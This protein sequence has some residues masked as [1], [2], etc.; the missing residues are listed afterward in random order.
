MTT[1]DVTTNPSPFLAPSSRQVPATQAL[2]MYEKYEVRADEKIKKLEN[3]PETITPGTGTLRLLRGNTKEELVPEDAKQLA[4][5][6]LTSKEVNQYS[7]TST[8]TD[9]L[10]FTERRLQEHSEMLSQGRGRPGDLDKKK[11]LFLRSEADRK[12]GLIVDVEDTFHNKKNP[13]PELVDSLSKELV[14]QSKVQSYYQMSK[15]KE[16]SSALAHK[17]TCQQCVNYL[18]ELGDA[19]VEQ[20]LGRDGKTW[21][22]RTSSLRDQALNKQHQLQKHGIDQDK[23]LAIA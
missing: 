13:T 5:K 3:A 9:S 15:D 11:L 7:V 23:S 12:A 2:A 8:L 21:V 18:K 10:N 6:A 22:C 1:S 14:S 17:H 20:Y 19:P 4:T 16:F